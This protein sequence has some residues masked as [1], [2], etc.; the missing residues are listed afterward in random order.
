MGEEVFIDTNVFLAL[1]LNEDTAG[2]CKKFLKSLETEGKRPATSDFI[3]HS[4]FVIVERNQKTI[5]ALRK[6]FMFFNQY[7]S[8]RI[9]RLSFEDVS[10][11]IDVMESDNLDF[12][13]GLV[14]ACMR[15]YGIKKLAS[16]DRHFNKVKGIERVKI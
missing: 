14:V 13:D 3:M 2:D 4:C 7:G 15:N 9:V 12:D 10:N 16:L 11:A 6:A 8:L 1:F 5:D